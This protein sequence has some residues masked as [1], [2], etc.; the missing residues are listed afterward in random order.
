MRSRPRSR[1][2]RTFL[3]TDSPSV[4]TT[5]PDSMA[6]SAICW[7]RWMWLAKLAV[8]TRR[9]SAAWN[10]LRSTA[11]TSRSLGAWPLAL[12]VGGVGHQQPDALGGGDGADAGEV[13]EP[14]VDRREV[15]LE[16]ARVQDD[17]LRACAR[18]WRGRGAPSG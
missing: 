15:E 17:A 6:A 13:G 9:P 11:P 5:R 18:R 12:G 4:A 8:M 10:V 14:A 1:A 16:V 2:R 7:M 3:R